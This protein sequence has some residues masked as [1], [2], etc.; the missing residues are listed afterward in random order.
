M[1]QPSSGVTKQTNPRM[2]LLLL[3]EKLP[4][5]LTSDTAMPRLL[6]PGTTVLPPHLLPLLPMQPASPRHNCAPSA[7]PAGAPISCLRIRCCR[8]QTRYLLGGPRAVE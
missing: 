7:A 5:V 1:I 3:S 6:P 4:V 2:L 8:A